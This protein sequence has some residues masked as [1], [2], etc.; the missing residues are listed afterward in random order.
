MSFLGESGYKF[1]VHE[2]SYWSKWELLIKCQHLAYPVLYVS[3]S[4]ASILVLFINGRTIDSCRPGYE[5]R[6]WR[7]IW[8]FLILSRRTRLFYLNSELSFLLASLPNHIWS[9]FFHQPEVLSSSTTVWHS[10][11]PFPIF[12]ETTAWMAFDHK[13]SEMIYT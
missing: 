4:E 7:I 3:I 6:L 1:S 12:H 9:N 13:P 5:S 8:K 10:C 11:Y 2:G